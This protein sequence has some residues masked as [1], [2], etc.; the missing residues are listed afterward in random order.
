MPR[1][2]PDF[3]IPINQ[4]ASVNIDNGT[5]YQ[6]LTGVRPIDGKGRIFWMDTFHQ[7]PS[8]MLLNPY[9]DALA[10]SVE[11]DVA[12]IQGASLKIPVGTLAGGG[13]GK[14][15]KKLIIPN[16]MK[17]GV[18]ASIFIAFHTETRYILSIDCNYIQ[19]H[20]YY[21]TIGWNISTGNIA[22]YQ[23]GI[24]IIVGN[25]LDTIDYNIWLPMKIVIDVNLGKYVRCIIGGIEIDLSAYTC[26]DSGQE[27]INTCTAAI[28]CYPTNNNV[29]RYGR[30]GYILITTDEP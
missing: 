18:E 5:L 21:G 12:F 24:W 28:L 2:T 10:P 14:A 3:G 23:G 6:G 15:Y 7:G 30:V 26:D 29:G 20:S 17:I 25:L 8:G 13:F 16:Q 27:I 19:N 1:G 9:G 22:I 4:I 11:T